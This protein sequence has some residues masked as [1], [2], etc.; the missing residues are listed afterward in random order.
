MPRVLAIL[1]LSSSCVFAEP[2]ERAPVDAPYNKVFDPW[3]ACMAA[4][5]LAKQGAPD[6]LRTLFLAAYVRVN[7]PFLGGEGEMTMVT[8]FREVVTAVGDY[9]FAR[10]LAAQ[11]PEVRSAVRSFLEETDLALKKCPRTTK[12]LRDAPKI[13]WPMDKAYRNDR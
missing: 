5:D 6:A 3:H 13:D 1:V 11:R 9:R 10:A 4:E 12:L 8:I 2:N 7:Q